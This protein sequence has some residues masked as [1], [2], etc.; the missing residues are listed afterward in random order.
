MT[1]VLDT[2]LRDNTVDPLMTEFGFDMT[3][4]SDRE[5]TI[6]PDTGA[7]TAAATVVSTTVTG[8]F[9]FF[10]QDEINGEDVLSGDLQALIG[11]K[12]VNDAGIVPDT[13]MQLVAKGITY[14][15]VR[16]TPTQPGGIAVLYRLQIRR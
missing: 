16:V 13:T 14:S 7:I 11:A 5:P 10:S 6:D 9:R 15:V 1:D 3:L 2:D 8:I 12:E 4:E